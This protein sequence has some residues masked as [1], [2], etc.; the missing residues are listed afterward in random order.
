MLN[1]LQMSWS[2]IKLGRVL[3]QGGFGVVYQ[4]KWQVGGIMGMHCYTKLHMM[5]WLSAIG[6]ICTCSTCLHLTSLSMQGH[7][8]SL[9]RST[10][11]HMRV[12][13]MCM[14]MQGNSV[15]VKIFE[16]LSANTKEDFQREA[17][18]MSMLRHPCIAHVYGKRGLAPCTL[19]ADYS[20]C[21]NLHIHPYTRMGHMGLPVVSVVQVWWMMVPTVRL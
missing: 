20:A 12:C 14:Y 15:A 11:Q 1:Q 21:G 4:A 13:I 5:A 17:L 9:A 8:Q 3:G 10:A 19:A 16:N 7:A 6:I 18:A 2:A